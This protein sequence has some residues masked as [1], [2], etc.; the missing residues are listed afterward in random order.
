MNEEQRN[1][2]LMDEHCLM[3]DALHSYEGY[4]ELRIEADKLGVSIKTAII[5]RLGTEK[6]QTVLLV[7]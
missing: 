3:F 6:N 4:K 1:C 2:V 5:D 7:E